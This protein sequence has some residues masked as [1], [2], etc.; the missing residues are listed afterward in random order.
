MKS[1]CVWLVYIPTKSENGKN[2]RKKEH[3]LDSSFRRVCRLLANELIG[4]TL[5]VSS[6]FIGY[7]SL[8]FPTSV[9]TRYCHIQQEP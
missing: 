3:D 5:F 2:K 8:D 9:G 1:T 6:F 4:V 7:L